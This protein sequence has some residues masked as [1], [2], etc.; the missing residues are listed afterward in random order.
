MS[1]KNECCLHS[2]L[3]DRCARTPLRHVLAVTGFGFESL[4]SP[5]AWRVASDTVHVIRTPKT[6]TNGRLRF[7]LPQLSVLWTCHHQKMGAV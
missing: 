7:V 5:S 4:S 2:I 3:P 1:S 6:S